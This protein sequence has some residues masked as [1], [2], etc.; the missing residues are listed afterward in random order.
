VNKLLAAVAVENK[1]LFHSKIPLITLLAAL[2]IPFMGGLFMFILKDPAF[3]QKMGVISAKAQIAGTADWS[4]YVSLLAQ[5]ISIGGLLIFGFVTSWVFGREYSD[6]TIKDLLALPT[7]RTV[8]VVSKFIVIFAWCLLLA[9]LAFGLGLL[10]GEFVNIPGWSY[11]IMKQGFS[12]FF[13]CAML[14]IVLSAPVALFASMGRGYLSPLGFVVFTLV[15][16]Q[17]VAATGYG[18]FFP[19]AVPALASGVSGSTQVAV[20]TISIIIV[21]LTSIVGLAG[22]LLWWRYADQN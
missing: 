9:V 11:E 17:I 5:A 19:W 14:T 20:E 16:A 7:S 12:V 4:S 13:S 22:T 10:V 6:R 15:L 8:I 18:E 3:A 2:L 21:F 1:K